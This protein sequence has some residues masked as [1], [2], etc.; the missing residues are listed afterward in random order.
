MSSK[1]HEA[2]PEVHNGHYE[3]ETLAYIML[4]LMFSI[5]IGVPLTVCLLNPQLI[6][7]ILNAFAGVK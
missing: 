6:Q 3:N 7:Q 2:L 5:M 4:Y 1:T